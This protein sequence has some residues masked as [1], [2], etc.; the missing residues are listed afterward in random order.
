MST[1]QG[2]I[3]LAIMVQ[4]N[5][6]VFYSASNYDKSVECEMYVKGTRSR[7]MLVE[8]AMNDYSAR[9]YYSSYY[10]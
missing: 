3:I 5:T 1:I 7:C 8:Y 2:F 6:L 4:R 9:F 10:R